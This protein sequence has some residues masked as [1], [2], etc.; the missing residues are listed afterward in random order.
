MTTWTLPTGVKAIIVAEL[1][2]DVSDS[3]TDYFHSRV[4]KTVY[5]AYSKHT[6]NLFSE[7]K[8]AA[9]RY[10][11]TAFLSVPKIFLVYGST[12]F[13]PHVR[14]SKSQWEDY[15]ERGLCGAIAQF[16]SDRHPMFT[17]SEEREKFLETIKL[18]ISAS[19]AE[20]SYERRETGAM[21]PGYYLGH[22]FSRSG[23]QI[24]KQ[25]SM[26]SEEEVASAKAEGRWLCD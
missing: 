10:E 17:S 12:E 14:L 11:E 25:R 26:P 1:R 13:N 15:S 6:R 3:M 20:K 2:E 21:C 7:M 23:W 18:P 8:K 9:K 5:L 19:M 4:V 16:Y 24:R 22:E